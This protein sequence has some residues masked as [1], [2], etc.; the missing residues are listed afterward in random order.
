MDATW[1]AIAVSYY[2]KI[3]NALDDLNISVKDIEDVVLEDDAIIEI[4]NSQ[5]NED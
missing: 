3:K 4:D 2:E 5:D 1:N